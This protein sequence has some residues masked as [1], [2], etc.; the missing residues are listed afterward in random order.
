[1]ETKK[2]KIFISMPFSGKEYDSL[3]QERLDLRTL[4]E[5]YGFE[6]TEQ[7]IGYQFKEDFE[8][9]DYDPKWVVGKDKNWLKQ[10]DVV[11]SDFSSPSM[12]TDFELILCKEVF[13][14]PVYAV[15]PEE[16][17]FH[18]WLKFY[19]DSYF[20]SVEEALQQIKKDYPN[21][22]KEIELVDKRQYDPI[23][24]EYRLVEETPAQKYVYD[25][26][27]KLQ[28]ARAGT[29]GKRVVVIHAGSGYRA[30]LVKSAGAAEVL[31]VD[32][33]YQSIRLAE[34]LEDEA[35]QG[36]QYVALD[37]FVNDVENNVPKDF[38]DN[39]DIVV[40]YFAFDH[41]MNRSEL[42]LLARNIQKLLKSGGVF[43]GMSDCPVG[44]KSLSPKYGVS[45]HF[46]EKN[47]H[48][49]EGKPRRISVYKDSMEVTH[50][51]NFTWTQKTIMEVLMDAKFT[52]VLIEP[53][54]VNDF[55]KAACGGDFW[56]EYENT[57]DQVVIF[58]KR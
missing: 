57:P 25:E 21:G 50:F 56:K 23:A 55:A 22:R 26:N 4:V 20:D 27:L 29:G 11:I 48:E 2:L 53:A 35:P 38:I 8:S 43:I 49:E 6:L 40:G 58:A 52:D 42:N 17:R 1:M 5:S 24:G 46:D 41:A 44:T 47:E 10:S 33:S 30:R 9:K 51:H 12:G 36:I 19:C 54:T 18:P 45:L 39:T 14:K 13:N 34:D 28:L 32:L 37:I 3:Y 31:G 15:V 16:K 7:F